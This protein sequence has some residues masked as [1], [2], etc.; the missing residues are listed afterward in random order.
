M[1]RERFLALG[2]LDEAHGSWGQFGT[3]LA[4]KS[5]LSGGQQVVNKLTW[6]A[7][8]FRT[9]SGFS[10]PYE[11]HGSQIQRAREYSQRLWLENRWPGQVRPLAWL[12]DYF[13]PIRGWHDP[14]GARQLAFVQ[15]RGKTF[16]A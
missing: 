5:W 13:A 16:T 14:E 8:L 1:R 9:R 12:L 15:A 11:Q 7:H 2:G 4:C 6:F 10:F 3:E